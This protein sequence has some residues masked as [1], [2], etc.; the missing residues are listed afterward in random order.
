M[1]AVSPT[2][3]ISGQSS[4]ILEPAI[5]IYGDGI[6]SD[7]L[8]AVYKYAAD[9]DGAF[10]GFYEYNHICSDAKTTSKADW[11]KFCS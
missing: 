11:T 3:R 5:E 4:V 2:E 10:P 9:A 7:F 8:A 1:T 6:L